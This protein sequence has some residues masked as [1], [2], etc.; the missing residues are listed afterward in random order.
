MR[1]ILC[2]IF[3]AGLIGIALVGQA[4]AGNL[5]NSPLVCANDA[6]NFGG[7]SNPS[8]T[9]QITAAGKLHLVLKN[10]IPGV[11]ATCGLV[12][13]QGGNIKGFPLSCGTA[14]SAGKINFSLND[15]IDPSSTLCRGPLITVTLSNG[16]ECDEGF[17]SGTAG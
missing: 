5:L 9:I 3:A 12:C 6:A 15:F 2:A 7:P 11:G 8:G 17:G 14:N 10:M 13:T 16:G 4:S 1:R